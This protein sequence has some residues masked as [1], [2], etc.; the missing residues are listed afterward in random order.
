MQYRKI[1]PNLPRGRLF[2]S[3]TCASTGFPLGAATVWAQGL[4]S[5]P[6]IAFGIRKLGVTNA[7]GFFDFSGI[8]ASKYYIF[9]TL[10]GYA[11]PATQLSRFSG[12]GVPEHFSAAEHVL[13]VALE[14]VTVAS[15]AATEINLSLVIGGTISGRVSWQDGSPAARNSMRLIFVDCDNRHHHSVRHEDVCAY[16]TETD[17]EGNYRFEGL[18]TGKYIVG[19]RAPKFLNYVR[20]NLMWNGIPPTISC[21]SFFYLT[22][23]T[24]NPVEAIPVE[25]ESGID[26][27]KI[28]LILPMLPVNP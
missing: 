12:F 2:G 8:P 26:I 7:N 27:S 18:F 19:A 9:A 21:A 17:D 1:D 13:D 20:K 6:D 16:G 11:S 3:V 28:D 25:I 14:R 4:K 24:A 22:G 23:N 15:E 10:R 5:E